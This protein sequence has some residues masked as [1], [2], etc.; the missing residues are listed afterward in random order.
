V[1]KATLS[2]TIKCVRAGRAGSK[3]GKSRSRS[4]SKIAALDRIQ[5]V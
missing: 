5:R 2:S 3:V 4:R 1:R